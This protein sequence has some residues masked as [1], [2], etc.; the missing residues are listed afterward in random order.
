MKYKVI[1]LFFNLVLICSCV[2]G[3]KD[4]SG[5]DRYLIIPGK[6]AEGFNL[7]DNVIEDPS[8]TSLKKRKT[9]SEIFGTNVLP[10]LCFD[11]VLY[12]GDSYAL[13]FENRKIVAIAGFKINKRV[14][15]DAVLL[16]KGIDNFI[17]NYGNDDLKIIT[18][19]NHKAYIYKKTGIAVFDD[20]NDNIIDMYI[21]FN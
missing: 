10:E 18:A 4:V 5:T 1:I 2:S 6:F 14:T 21:I 16:S 15:S 20:N 12:A 13:L 19:G 17:M 8:M 9:V 3:N 11:S 7:G